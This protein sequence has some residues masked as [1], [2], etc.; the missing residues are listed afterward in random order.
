MQIVEIKCSVCDTKLADIK[1]TSFS[2]R[3][4]SEYRESF[5]CDCGAIGVPSDPR[6]LPVED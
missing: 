5:S 4:M 6:E 3:D 1:K 2:E